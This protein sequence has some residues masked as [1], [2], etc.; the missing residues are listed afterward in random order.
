MLLQSCPAV[1]DASSWGFNKLCPPFPQTCLYTPQPKGGIVPLATFVCST[2]ALYGVYGV[3]PI[4]NHFVPPSAIHLTS[5]VEF[6]IWAAPPSHGT[7]Y[8]PLH[9]LLR[10]TVCPPLP[11]YP[12]PSP[13][14][15]TA[16]CA[17]GAFFKS[18]FARWWFF[19]WLHTANLSCSCRWR[20]KS[21]L[22]FM[23]L[24]SKSF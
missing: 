2:L 22:S 14:Y 5:R 16:H 18:Y 10:L 17:I 4:T 12:L 20:G 15:P 24:V 6:Q 9:H 8:S 1:A 21:A 23:V 3:H 13:L 7:P 19:S 11:P